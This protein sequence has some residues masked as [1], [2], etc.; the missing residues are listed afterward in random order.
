M[1]MKKALA[2][3]SGVA[4]ISVAFWWST[5]KPRPAILLITIDTLRADRLGAYGNRSVETPNLDRF[6]GDGIVFSQASATVPL[7]LPSHASILTGRYPFAHGVRDNGDCVLPGSVPT[8]AERLKAGG[9][10]TG[11]FV[12]SYVLASR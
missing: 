12:G 11:A 2:G 10:E 6:A 1:S 9:Y 3:L 4:V 8:L 7:T 5:P